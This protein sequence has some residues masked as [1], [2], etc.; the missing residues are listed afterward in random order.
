MPNSIGPTGLQV[1]TQAELVSDFTTAFQAIYGADINLDQDSPDGQMM[2]IYIQALLDLSDLL[3]QVYN[4]FDPDNALGVV[5]DQRV[6]INGI[7]RQA[8]TYTITNITVVTT[9]A[10]NLYGLDQTAETVFTISDNVGTIWYLITTQSPSG[11]GTYVYQFRA[12]DP[13]A[14]LT[15]PNTITT[16]VTTTIGVSSVNNPTTYLTLGLNEETDAAL[17]VRRQQSVS[18]SSQGYYDALLAALL[19]ITGV[20]SAY[21]HENLTGSTDA[22]GVPSHSIWVIVGG[23]AANSD[24]AQAIYSKRNA[25][26]GM[27]GTTNY[28][29]TQSDGSPF[30]VTWDQTVAQPLYIKFTAS[31]LDGVNPP[32]IEAI[33]T[34][35]AQ[36]YIPG[37]NEQVNVNDLATYVQ[38]IDNNCLVTNAGFSTSV[39]GTYTNTLSPTLKNYYFTISSANTQIIPMLI[40]PTNAVVLASSQTQY[41][42]LGG[43]GAYTYS[44]LVNNSGGSIT[45]G[46]LYTAG[47]SGFTDTIKVL[48]SLGNFVT[49][50]VV[51]V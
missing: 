8:G 5:L 7:Q 38:Q 4:Q 23:T 3:V 19:N 29:V 6:A 2:M 33:R 51:V 36:L 14:T 16:I 30:T 17:K 50:T 31:S 32:N 20:T 22:Y 48:D 9:A 1:K 15:T 34:G 39:G 12:A 13:G 40:T 11:A 49:T 21:I 28:T 35:L 43:Y 18:L 24:I 10:L 47:S 42:G 46:G 41:T 25:G 37:V 26:C 45:S 27:Y 44:I